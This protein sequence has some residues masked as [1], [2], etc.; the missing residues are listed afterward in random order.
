MWRVGMSSDLIKLRFKQEIEQSARLGGISSEELMKNE[1]AEQLFAWFECGYLAAIEDAKISPCPK[2]EC[3]ELYDELV[4]RR[5]QVR[6]LQKLAVLAVSK[7]ETETVSVTSSS[8]VF[9]PVTHQES[10][11]LEKDMIMVMEDYEASPYAL[12][13][14]Y[15][16][17]HIRYW[18]AELGAERYSDLYD[19]LQS[20]SLIW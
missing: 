1:D 19:H 3:Q 11:Q 12:F 18:R 2:P 20:K 15:F 8:I 7:D 13:E 5:Q 17:D 9:S 16:E 4:D 10:T 14:S 6:D